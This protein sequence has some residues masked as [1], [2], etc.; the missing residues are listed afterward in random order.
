MSVSDPSRT[1]PGLF[2]AD[3][4]LSDGA[5]A[6]DLLILNQ[7]IASFDVFSRLW[8]HAGYRIC[9]D[10]GANRLYDLFEGKLEGLRGDY[11]RCGIS[12]AATNMPLLTCC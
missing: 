7:P 9:A 4:R 11:V 8:E 2:L 1:N 6:P 10:G 3:G 12:L 5:G